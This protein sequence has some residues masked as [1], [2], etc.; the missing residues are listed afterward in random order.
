MVGVQWFMAFLSSAVILVTTF[1]TTIIVVSQMGFYA[2]VLW[3]SLP[4]G[5]LSY[6]KA[7][8]LPLEIK[9]DAYPLN[10]T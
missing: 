6:L 3:F 9:T 4:V 1:V 5:A 10:G 8:F 2:G 7:R